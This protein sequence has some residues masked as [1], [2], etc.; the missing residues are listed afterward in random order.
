M[1]TRI[2]GIAIGLGAIWAW[3]PGCTQPAPECT[4][5]TASAYPYIAKFIP[6]GDDCAAIPGDFVGM[7]V[8]NPAGGTVPDMTIKQVALQTFTAGVYL[9]DAIELGEGSVPYSFGTFAN[10]EPDGSNMCSVPE[11]SPA[12][13]V[14]PEIPGE[15]GGGG[16]G[17]G[18]PPPA[19]EAV[20]IEYRWS[21]L[22]LYVTPANLGNQ[23][24]A[25]LTFVDGLNDCTSNYH[26]VMLWPAIGCERLTVNEEG[27]AVG[28][29][30]PEPKLCD[31]NPDPEEPYALDSGSGISPNLQVVCDPVLLTCVLQGDAIQR[32][33]D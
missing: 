7:Q 26:V 4:V 16:A 28:T 32:V 25:D 11:L 9:H 20:D 30:E 19:Q 17:G 27:E 21:N 10:I 23:A 31:Q 12:H 15:A 33:D 2:L 1:K 3:S 22:K 14:L 13:M 18:P 29:G 8:Y 6:Q 5:G 24:E